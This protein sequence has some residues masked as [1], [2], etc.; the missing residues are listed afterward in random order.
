VTS[1][2]K[3]SKFERL[4]CRFTLNFLNILVTLGYNNKKIFF[5]TDNTLLAEQTLLN[6]WI[7]NDCN[8]NKSKV[9]SK[10]KW[11]GKDNSLIVLEDYC[12]CVGVDKANLKKILYL[13]NK[14][15]IILGVT[16]SN[17]HKLF[18]DKSIL[19]NIVD[20]VTT[21]FYFFILTKMYLLGVNWS[22]KQK[23]QNYS[24]LLI[25][26]YRTNE[27]LLKFSA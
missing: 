17:K 5:V 19:V 1:T 24:Q 8:F 21:Y 9:S 26:F 7:Y 3:T 22:K 23:L 4:N 12:V 20:P 27:L 13:K 11:F 6:L 2:R 18:F 25:S 10:L 16:N 15:S 14:N